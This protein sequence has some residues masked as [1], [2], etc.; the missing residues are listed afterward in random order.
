MA[1]DPSGNAYVADTTNCVIRKYTKSTGNITTVAGNGTCGLTGDGRPATSAELNHRIGVALGTDGKLYIADARQ[2]PHPDRRPRHR[3]HRHLRR[4]VR[5]RADGDRLTTAK[6]THRSAWRS[7]PRRDLYVADSGNDAIRE[8]DHTSGVVCTDRRHARRRRQLRRQR[9]GHERLLNDP[10]AIT[11]DQ[12]D[13]IFV[14]D[15]RQLPRALAST[16]A[17]A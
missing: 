5:R 12:F 2:Q 6:F 17:A 9:G 15:T 3:H 4:L 8:I 16:R 7:T 10:E 11:I 14:A 1:V 13:E